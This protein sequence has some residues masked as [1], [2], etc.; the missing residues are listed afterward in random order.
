MNSSPSLPGVANKILQY[1]NKI[2]E[3][4]GR[5]KR[6][7]FLRIAGNEEI[8]NDWIEYLVRCNL[9]RAETDDG[10]N[11]YVKTELGEKMQQVLKAHDYLGPLLSDLSRN[12]RKP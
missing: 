7:D 12:R 4:S 8:L 10:K 11:Y 5:A 2:S 6:M 9:V 3:G 1:L